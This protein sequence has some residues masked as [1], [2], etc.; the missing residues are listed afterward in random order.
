VSLIVHLTRGASGELR[1]G[2]I[3]EV[4][5]GDPGE[6]PTLH[7]IFTFKPDQTGGRFAATGH[8]P[9]WAEGAPPS[10]FR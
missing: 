1:V 9:A 3:T 4:R 7:P 8:V 10:T 5:P 6:G 2:E